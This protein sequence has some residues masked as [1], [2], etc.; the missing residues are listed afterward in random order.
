M[1]FKKAAEGQKTFT[2]PVC[3]MRESTVGS[4]PHTCSSSCEAQYTFAC[5]LTQSMALENEEGTHH[6]HSKANSQGS[7]LLVTHWIQ[8]Y[9]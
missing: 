7:M 2:A 9:L 8:A 1:F 3:A 6:S 5:F 4:N